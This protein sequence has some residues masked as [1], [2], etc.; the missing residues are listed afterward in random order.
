MDLIPIGQAARQLRVRPSTLRYYDE[1]GL[2]HPASRQGSRRLYGTGELRRLAF[3]RLA[4]Q[5]GLPLDAAAMI[6]DAPSAQWRQI[7]AQQVDEFDQL[8]AR[9]TGAR[10]LLKHTLQ[11]PHDHPTRECSS[12]VA[13]LD[14]LVE[15][16]PFDQLA[17]E[18]AG[19]G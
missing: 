1:R 6:L 13:T 8:I 4:H 14:R 18:H 11:C 10:E 16:T 7:V 9:A 12:L 17:S 15:G 5:L 19:T 2:V 3:L